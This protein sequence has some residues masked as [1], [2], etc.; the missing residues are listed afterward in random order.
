MSLSLQV[1]TKTI[2]IISIIVGLAASAMAHTA[3]D[4]SDIHVVTGPIHPQISRDGN[5][6]VF[7]IQGA[8][9][10]VSRNGGAMTRLTDEPGFDIEP[11]WSPDGQWIAFIR[12]PDFTAG[13]LEIIS[14]IDGKSRP[15]PKRIW[16]GDR[17]FF[18]RSGKRLL[19]ALKVDR[20]RPA[21]RWL[22]LESGELGPEL[23]PFSTRER[24]A[25]SQ[26]G[27][28]I[29][30]IE[31]RDIGGVEQAGNNGPQSTVWS[32]PSQGGS[33]TL[34][35]EF[36]ARIYDLSWTDD[37]SA[38]ILVT[39]AGGVHNDLWQVPL[40][41]SLDGAQRIT[42]GSA[43]ED[44]PTLSRDSRWL[45][46]TDNQSGPTELMIRN[47][48]TGRSRQVDFE[49][50][51]YGQ[52]VGQL[53]LNISDSDT[54]QPV[55][56]RVSVMRNGGKYHAPANAIYRLQGKDM[57][58][59]AEET[60]NLTVPEG[61]YQ[62]TAWRGPE[63]K[64]VQ[65]EV[66]VSPEQTSEV[67]LSMPRWIDQRSRGWYSGESHIHANYG[68]GNWYNSPRT[69]L[70]QCAGEDLLV[71]N[72]M[73][74]NSDTDGVYDREYFR[75]GPDP[76]STADTR[77]HWN[78]EFRSTIWGH[79]T[80][81]NLTYLVEPIFTGFAH[82]THPHDH[83]TNG[84]V[85]DLTH[86]QGGH[87][88]YTHPSQNVEDPYSSA[89]SAKELPV[90]VALGKIDSIDVMGSNQ[91]AN[92]KL[93]Y[94][95]LNCG[96]Q[97]PA[98]AGTDCFLNRIR[99]RLPGSVRAYVKVDGPFSYE[100]WIANLQLGRSFATN[101]P[102]FEF[103]AGGKSPGE[104]VTLNRPGEI[105]VTGEVSS[106]YPLDRAEVIFN[107]QVIASLDAP[108]SASTLIKIGRK[109]TIPHSG[110]IALRA[111]GPRDS[112][113]GTAPFGH[114][115][116]IYITVEGKPQDASE[117]ARYFISWI[118]RLWNDVQTRDRIPSRHLAHVE[119]QIKQARAVYQ[120]LAE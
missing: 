74:A 116:P 91:E 106:L 21:L 113:A 115:S 107:G 87:V 38:L 25:L 8:I 26:D 6:M 43:D 55:T 62:I 13:T 40:K 73:V 67:T 104:T 114:T 110:W 103:S 59:Y 9:W 94:G 52:P 64:V 45:L 60:S 54:G 36:P 86:D 58:F 82:T 44:R 98:S 96:F 92:M 93:W 53:H 15:L 63:Y 65:Q 120:A 117:D 77:L 99:S 85:A 34:L 89:Y 12:S 27:N 17:L 7:S 119:S 10:K 3:I 111:S 16:A 50:S 42:F 61:H 31:S 70:A 37:D 88:N 29:V 14:A 101:G 81:L 90:D 30:W 84:D 19:G 71:C 32:M 83:P 66:H 56:A 105:A 46:Y 5:Q 18:D 39:D 97:I 35:F 108:A 51:N 100:S 1:V 80:L 118:D 2:T 48:A 78:E 102:M 57:H 4:N 24:Y 41:D 68:Y 33:R 112:E 20:E 79:M 69:M 23:K 95:L 109:V 22:D 72:F 75:G 49:Q 47:Q 28:R 11:S 76:L